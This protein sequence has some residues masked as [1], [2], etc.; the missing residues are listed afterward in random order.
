MILWGKHEGREAALRSVDTASFSAALKLETGEKVGKGLA[1]FCLVYCHWSLFWLTWFSTLISG[2]LL[3]LVILPQVRLPYEQF[4]KTYCDDILE[5]K[6]EPKKEVK[7]EY[8]LNVITI[9]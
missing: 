8:S 2:T 3:D 5:V 6:V 9:D 7:K 1:I 4:S